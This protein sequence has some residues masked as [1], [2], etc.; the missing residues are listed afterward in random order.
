LRITRE[1]TC[2]LLVDVQERLFPH[3]FERST[4]E[5]NLPILLRGLRILDIPLLV[6]QQYTKG[7]G[8]TIPLLRDTLGWNGDERTA[9]S[10]N[11]ADKTAAAGTG[12]GKPYVGKP[13]VGKP[14]IEKIAFSCWGEPEFRK[15]LKALGRKRVL[16][17][18]IE[19]HICV[20]QTAIDLKQA[21]YTPVVIEDCTSCRR[22]NDRRTA[23]RRLHAEGILIS[24][25]ESILFELMQEAG[26]VTFRAISR[27]VTGQGQ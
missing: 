4:L 20:L 21:G 13:Y 14:Y 5:R 1:Q 3:M 15:A 16:L 26:T 8:S 27:L 18:G 17:A 2:A 9:D 24:S 19:A 6:T 22:E 25:Y 23:L 12:A 7:L 10:S 11:R